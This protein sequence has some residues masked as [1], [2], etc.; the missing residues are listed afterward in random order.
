MYHNVCVIVVV[1]DYRQKASSP[2]EELRFEDNSF[3]WDVN[4]Y[5]TLVNNI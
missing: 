1:Y 2:A 4:H 5:P 3:Q